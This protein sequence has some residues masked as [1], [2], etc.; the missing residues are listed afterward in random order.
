[1]KN[2]SVR[3]AFSIPVP[4]PQSGSARENPE[5]FHVRLKSGFSI[6]PGNNEIDPHDFVV[7]LLFPGTYVLHSDYL[8]FITKH[9]DFCR[10]ISPEHFE[11]LSPGDHL[12]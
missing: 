11:F 3:S 2:R 5:T 1:M 4:N 10:V 8:P 6:S 9:K 7:C 12:S